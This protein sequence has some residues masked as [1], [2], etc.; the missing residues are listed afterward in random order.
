MKW[1]AAKAGVLASAIV[2]AS[3]AT[4]VFTTAAFADVRVTR[5]LGG[6][7]T[8]YIHKFETIRDSGERLIIDGQCLSACT[9]F[10]AIVPRDQ[11]CVT[12]RAVLGFHAATVYDSARRTLVPTRKGT[13]LVVQLYPPEIRE[14]IAR[15]GGLT[16]TIIMMRGRELAALYKP[17][18]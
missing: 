10:T 16:P 14:W 5:D 8:R 9:L 15:H 4:L 6:E 11:V 2:A 7:V 3:A 17:C 13:S 12:R 1:Q 18:Q